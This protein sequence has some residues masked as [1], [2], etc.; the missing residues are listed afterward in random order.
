[1][2]AI[3]KYRMGNER[4]LHTLKLKKGFK[5][6]HSEYIVTDK[7][8]FLWVEEPLAVDIETQEVSYRLAMSGDP[9]SD[10]SEHVAT[11]IDI[12]G[13]EAYHIFEEGKQFDQALSL[14]TSHVRAA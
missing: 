10:Q 9:V 1:M 13:P 6:V 2:K 11:A 3:H 5:I 8:V 4:N 7:A 14:T 12:F